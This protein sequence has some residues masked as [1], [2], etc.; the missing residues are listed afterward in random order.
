ML[1]AALGKVKRVT[2]FAHYLVWAFL[3]VV[4]AAAYSKK[5]FSG[6]S[7]RVAFLFDLY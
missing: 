3:E 4:A 5:Q 6:D 7:D 2:N 1:P